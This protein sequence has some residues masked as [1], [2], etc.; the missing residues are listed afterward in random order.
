M[1]GILVFFGDGLFSG[2]MLR[3]FREG[4]NQPHSSRYFVEGL[5][6]ALI[7]SPPNGGESIG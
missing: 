1:V 6:Q 5:I 2:A 3:S 4:M 7:C